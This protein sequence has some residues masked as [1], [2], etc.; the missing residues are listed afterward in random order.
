METSIR[1]KNFS[2]RKLNEINKTLA[3]Q[4]IKTKKQTKNKQTKNT[5]GK[6]S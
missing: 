1:A 2:L 5:E 4:I 6:A 3:R